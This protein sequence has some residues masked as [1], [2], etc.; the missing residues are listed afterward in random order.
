MPLIPVQDI[1]FQVVRV[2]NQFYLVDSSKV[3]Q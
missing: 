1:F 2:R 3:I